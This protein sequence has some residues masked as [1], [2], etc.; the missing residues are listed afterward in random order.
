M[1]A[2]LKPRVPIP[3]DNYVHENDISDHEHVLVESSLLVQ[4]ARYSL[5]IPMIKDEIE[6]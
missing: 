5:A 4:V 6:Y 2:L 3:D 1:D